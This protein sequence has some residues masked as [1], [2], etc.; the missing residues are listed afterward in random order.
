MSINQAVF[1]YLYFILREVKDSVE[2]EDYL[3]NDLSY[4]TKEML[5]GLY[6]LNNDILLSLSE[7]LFIRAQQ[8]IYDHFTD[9]KPSYNYALEHAKMLCDYHYR[10]YHYLRN[11]GCDSSTIRNA[12]DNYMY[13]C[14]RANE[15]R[16]YA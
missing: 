10:N 2:K 14:D 8:E 13:A 5:D 1:D 6:F 15:L 16:C 3:N 9:Y 11:K 7:P 12:L 4:V